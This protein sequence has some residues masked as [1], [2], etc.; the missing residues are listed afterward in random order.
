MSLWSYQVVTGGLERVGPT[1]I[2]GAGTEWLQHPDVVE[3]FC[4]QEEEHT[5]KSTAGH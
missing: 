4:L 1:H 5:N 2:K 3:A